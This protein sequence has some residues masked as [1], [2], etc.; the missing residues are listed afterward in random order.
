[1]Y[2]EYYG[3]ARKLGSVAKNYID[4][5]LFNTNPNLTKV[6]HIYSIPVH[7]VRVILEIAPA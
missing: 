1:M 3:L 4:K 2:N 5:I 6:N 7:Y